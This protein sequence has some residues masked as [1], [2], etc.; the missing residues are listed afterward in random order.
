MSLK[1]INLSIETYTINKT[2][3]INNQMAKNVTKN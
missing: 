3:K 2:D 1:Q